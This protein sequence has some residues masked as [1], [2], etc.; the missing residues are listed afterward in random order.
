MITNYILNLWSVRKEY[1]PQSGTGAECWLQT[2]LAK[3]R[4]PVQAAYSFERDRDKGCDDEDSAEQ[5]AME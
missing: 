4:Q 5:T 3:R 1:K 2:T